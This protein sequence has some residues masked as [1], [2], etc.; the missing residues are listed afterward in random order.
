MKKNIAVLMLEIL[1]FELSNRVIY[2]ITCYADVVYKAEFYSLLHVNCRHF[3]TSN[4][5]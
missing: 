4:F 1:F 3:K 5:T 2:L